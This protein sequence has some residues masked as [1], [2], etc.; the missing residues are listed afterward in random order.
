MNFYSSK[1]VEKNFGF[2][3][4]LPFIGVSFYFHSL[5]VALFPLIASIGAVAYLILYW[6]KIN[7][8]AYELIRRYKIGFILLCLLCAYSIAISVIQKF[9]LEYEFRA[10]PFFGIML[11][12]A[13]F[14][15]INIWAK[16]NE[17]KFDYV[18]KIFLVVILLFFYLQFFSYVFAGIEVDYLVGVTGEDQR[19][20]GHSREIQGIGLVR[21]SSGI[22]AEPGVHSYYVIVMLSIL[23]YR[24]ACGIIL[25]IL[26]VTSVFLSFSASGMVLLI[27]PL[28]LSIFESKKL[29]WLI[30]L[31][32][33]ISTTYFSDK[34]YLIFENDILRL[35]DP[36]ND[37]SG[38]DRI[39]FIYLLLKDGVRFLVGYGL[40][41]DVRNEL[42]PSAF[43]ASA[44]FI[45]GLVGFIFI[46]WLLLF[47]LR[48]QT[49]MVEIF[50]ILLLGVLLN[51]GVTSVFFWSTFSLMSA[52]FSKNVL[53]KSTPRKKAMIKSLTYE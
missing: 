22:F 30:I 41:L 40:I 38:S 33:L 39:R 16:L 10:N 19:L 35:T 46:G 34:L 12:F 25:F 15:S 4:I 43:I 47:L 5:G 52:G 6:R 45:F 9:T 48:R 50:I 18:I 42:P 13:S 37:A 7:I 51:F 28:L 17:K 32:V 21:R 49:N 3:L 20:V 29:R 2:I 53:H 23:I 44:N 8:E 26:S 14:A 27:F 36:I 24:R 31:V 1:K 11:G